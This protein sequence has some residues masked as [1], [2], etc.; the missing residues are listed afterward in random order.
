MRHPRHLPACSAQYGDRCQI[1]HDAAVGVWLALSANDIPLPD[2]PL[3]NPALS[4]RGHYWVA[5]RRPRLK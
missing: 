1:E 3:C 2:S 4:P 5:R